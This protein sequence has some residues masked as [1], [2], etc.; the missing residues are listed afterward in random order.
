MCPRPTA[1]PPAPCVTRHATWPAIGRNLVGTV[2]RSAHTTPL[3]GYACDLPSDQWVPST[4]R[5]STRHPFE[6]ASVMGDAWLDEQTGNAV[7][8]SR[9]VP[10]GAGAPTTSAW[11]MYLCT[12]ACDRRVTD[13]E[14]SRQSRRN[15]AR[16]DHRAIE[17]KPGTGSRLASLRCVL[18]DSMFDHQLDFLRAARKHVYRADLVHRLRLA[19]GR[20]VEDRRADRRC[21]EQPR[22]HRRTKLHGDLAIAYPREQ[23][24]LLSRLRPQ[25]LRGHRPAVRGQ[26][27]PDRSSPAEIEAPTAPALSG[28][29][30]TEL[31]GSSCRRLAARVATALIGLG[32]IDT[33]A[34][35]IDVF[36]IESRAL[37]P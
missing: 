7:A 18:S 9:P 16:V 37:V 3:L 6:R 8:L 11:M 36:V 31:T 27:G 17:A 13:E 32:S 34:Q 2:Q 14:T 28:G 22:L 19:S 26:A 5:S 29:P 30:A 33:A 21:H 4:G 1:G 23:R 24:E 20:L 25:Q 10:N 15:L 35:F 12:P